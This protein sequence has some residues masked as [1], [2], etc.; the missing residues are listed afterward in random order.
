CAEQTILNWEPSLVWHSPR[1]ADCGSQEPVGWQKFLAQS[2]QPTSP[3]SGA[4]IP[5][6]SSL[7]HAIS[8]SHRNPGAEPSRASRTAQTPTSAPLLSG[9]AKSGSHIPLV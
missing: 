3:L 2:E 6:P 4:N 9:T 5:C 7:T 8:V 1:T